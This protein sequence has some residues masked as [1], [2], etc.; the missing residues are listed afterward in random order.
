MLLLI[1]FTFGQS[2]SNVEDEIAVD[3]LTVL[4][5]CCSDF[6]YNLVICWACLLT[7]QILLTEYLYCSRLTVNLPISPYSRSC[8]S[9][10][11]S[12]SS[13]SAFGSWAS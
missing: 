12:Y 4:R 11:A 8:S 7:V 5:Q 2:N 9:S 6:N 1:A 13:K 3:V 10:R